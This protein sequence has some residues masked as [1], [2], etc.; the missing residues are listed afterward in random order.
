MRAL[1][2]VIH[3]ALELY[4]WAIIIVALMSWLI[5]FNVINIHNNMVRSIWNGLNALVEPALRR[6][7]RFLPDMGGVDISPIILIFIIWFI[8][9]ELTDLFRAY[10]SGF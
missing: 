9:M 1:F 10:A 7:R 4:K 5:S 8:Q 2:V 3:E 6:I